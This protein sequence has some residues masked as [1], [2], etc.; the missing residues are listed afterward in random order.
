[1]RGLLTKTLYEVWLPTLLYGIGLFV[2]K[3]ILTY[4]LPQIHEAL[5][6]VLHRLPFA[7]TFLTILLGNTLGAEISARSMQAFLYVHPVVLALVWAH[8]VTLCTRMPAAEIDRGTIDVLLSLPV[9]RRAVYACESAVWLISGLF[10]L[11]MG[12][13]GHLIA[14]PRMPDELRPELPRIVFVLVNLYCVYIAVGGIALLVSAMSDHRGRA[15]AVV[16]A[17]LLA[18][19]LLNFIANFWEPAKQIAFLGI[20]EYYRPAQVLQNGNFPA[21]DVIV[22]LAV[23]LA[24]WLAG[25]E[26]LARRSITT[27]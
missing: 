19:F 16:F 15:V 20:L 10:V 4:I 23:G 24:T 17:I 26:I 14:A 27:V 3:M 7:R 25:G 6:E 11:M 5:G 22:L 8:A 18:S 21:R 1:M 9:S 13:A 12:L 2:V